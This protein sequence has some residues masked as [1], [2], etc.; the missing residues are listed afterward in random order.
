[1]TVNSFIYSAAN[2][3]T[4]A[5]LITQTG[6]VYAGGNIT[7]GNVLTGGYVSATGNIETSANVL[8]GGYVSA[9]GNV[10]GGN[11]DTIGLITATGNIETSANVLVGGYVSATGNVEGGNIRTGNAIFATGNV[12]G[13]NLVS[14]G[15]V[16]V[17]GNVTAGNVLTGGVVS[18]TG[19]V[20]GGNINT[21]GTVAGANLLLNQTY[22]FTFVQGANVT[23]NTSATIGSDNISPGSAFLSFTLPSAG[24]WV[25]A[26]T[27]RGALVN[28]ANPGSISFGLYQTGNLVTNTETM[29]IY[30][31]S[32]YTAP[33]NAQGSTSTTFIVNTVAST[34]YTL[35]A[36][37]Q[38]AAT[39]GILSDG[40]GRTT[41]NWYK[42][43]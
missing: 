10:R 37:G 31:A 21:V 7:G 41:V 6:Y 19:N 12:R 25:V 2:I 27:V 22:P 11:I 23:A 18:A 42:I 1:L 3:T 39:P 16:T 9:T 26:P 4:A 36:F 8:V 13:G 30:N 20:R 33:Y 32:L 40:N 17:A 24:T 15:L 29:V 28:N 38:Y 43:G 35:N 34:E 5:N 14:A